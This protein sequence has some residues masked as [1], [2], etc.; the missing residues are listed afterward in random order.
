[1]SKNINMEV[2]KRLDAWA[3]PKDVRDVIDTTEFR[4]IAEL[5]GDI[6]QPETLVD[7]IRSNWDI[8]TDAYTWEELTS[9]KY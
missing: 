6:G 4:M 9:W 5:F 1:M 7:Y 2:G 8:D 3:I